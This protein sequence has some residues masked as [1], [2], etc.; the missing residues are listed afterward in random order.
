MAASATEGANDVTTV[1]VVAAQ[2]IPP[3]TDAAADCP[4]ALS[5]ELD[6]GAEDEA[7]QTANDDK[8]ASLI[9]L[10][11]AHPRDPG[12]NG[13]LLPIDSLQSLA[14][15]E[16]EIV[17]QSEV[18]FVRVR[19]NWQ[20]WKEVRAGLFVL[21]D[22]AMRETGANS[23]KS[24]LYKNRFHELLEQRAYCSAKM[25]P[26]IRKALLKCAE[27]APEIDEWHD[28]LDECRRLRLN[29]PITVLHAFR[30]F[31]EPQ[32]PARRSRRIEHELELAKVR[33]EAAAAVSSRDERIDEMRQEIDKLSRHG[34]IPSAAD[35]DID[36]IARY[37]ITTCDG[38]A[39]K[40]REVIDALKAHLEHGAS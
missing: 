4:H 28:N 31:Q 29:N 19:Q 24:K 5:T 18:A 12:G 17:R 36:S 15:E 40:I 38:D 23:P 6:V 8:S 30:K 35:R 32:S 25:D 1:T 10:Q 37:V 3:T 21:R 22:L 39:T 13:E 2:A 20:G 34:G 33:Q 14:A 9:K 27:L 7:S 16:R 11:G 26:S